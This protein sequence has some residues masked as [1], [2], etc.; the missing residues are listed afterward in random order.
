MAH[1][2]Q[3]ADELRAAL[4]VR[5]VLQHVQQLGV[6]GRV[7]LA[8][9]VARGVDA[10]RAAEEVHGE[11]GVIGQRRQAG[12]PRGVARL[13]DGVLDEGQAGF[14]R[15]HVA[16]FAD[17]AHVHMLAEHGLQ[18]LEFAGVVTGQHQLFELDHSSGKISCMNSK[19][20]GASLPAW[21]WM[22]KVRVSR[23]VIGN[24]AR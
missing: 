7:A 18:F 8:V 20:C 11:P 24:C 16:E 2:R 13:E 23:C 10:R 5:Y 1:Q 9:G 3:H 22:L 12:H 14:F 21:T 17:G 15:L 4:G 6:V 19:L